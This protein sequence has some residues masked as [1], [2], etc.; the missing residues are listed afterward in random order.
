MMK[1][2][3][4]GFFAIFLLFILPVKILALDAVVYN[5]NILNQKVVNE[6]NKMGKELFEKGEIFLGVAVG[7]K[8]SMQ[9]LSN[10]KE[11]LP[12]SYIL[13]LLSTNSKKVDIIGSKGALALID[14]E[15][16]LSPYPGTGSILPILATK[17]GDIYNAAILNGYADISDRLAKAL[18]IK[19]ENSVGNANKDTINILRILIYG[20]ICFALLYYAHRRMKRRK[21]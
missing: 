13:L 12:K 7:E 6:L 11:Q 15:A 19:L 5:E 16:V 8:S 1:K 17:K 3:Q 2:L 9:D 18:N 21:I 14:K 20:F 4:D 10:F